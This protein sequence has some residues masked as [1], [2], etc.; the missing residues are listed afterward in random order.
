MEFS[1]KRQR[2]L[3]GRHHYR[4]AL[5]TAAGLCRHPVICGVVVALSVSIGLAVSTE[6]EWFEQ[7]PVCGIRAEHLPRLTLLA[8]RTGRLD[9]GETTCFAVSLEAGEFVRIVGEV[10]AGYLRAQ[11]LE[12]QSRTPLQ[13][14]WLWSF[15]YSL[16]LAFEAPTSGLY[17]VELSAP[18]AAPEV[19]KFRIQI[20]EQLSARTQ[21]AR[22]Q[23]LRHDPRTEWLR[24]HAMRI[25]SIEPDDENFSDLEFLREPLRGVRVVLLG[26]GDHGVGSD[27]KAKTRL[28]KFLHGQM[29]FDVLAFESG[30]FS[31]SE[32]WLA[33]QTDMDP[34]EAFARGAAGVWARSE[35]VQPLIKYLA[36]SART[37]HPLELTGVGPDFTGTAARESLLPRLQEFLEG[38]GLGGPLADE[39]SEETAILTGVVDGR[40]GREE[41]RLPT[42]TQQARLTQALRAAAEH[43]EQRDGGRESS[44]WSQ[45]LRSTAVQVALSLNGIR[46]PDDKVAF[47]GRERQ[48]IENLR[49]LVE[50]RYAGRKIIVWVHTVHAMRNPQHTIFGREYGITMGQG[51]WEALGEKSFVIGCTS[52]RGKAYW[53]TQPEEQQQDI[54][55]DA[56]PSF[57]FEE[58]MDAAGHQFAWVNLR[59][60]RAEG[61]WLG[62]SFVARPIYFRPERAPWSDVLDALI[63]VHTQ[64]P[65]QRV[66]QMK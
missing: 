29:G 35:Q 31:M 65:S 21:A 53:V 40:F 6:A 59:S 19:P 1:G 60:A 47:R 30:L 61:Q 50:K 57:E 63:F 48:M 54:V 64:E 43:L 20:N 66:S 9:A 16:P 39:G 41:A 22:R 14:T 51:V 8:P 32:A 17:V 27:F 58:M 12:P 24:Q 46:H 45:A 7:D 28:I 18:A 55:A 62:G 33:L 25:R 3:Y 10:E 23:D 13:V 49:W 52:Y 34:R 26:E 42:S 5:P 44:F 38:S 37:N 56:H 4:C 36:L 11:V 15:F 2:L